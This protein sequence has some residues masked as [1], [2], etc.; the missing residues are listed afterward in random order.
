MAGSLEGY[1]HP[2][3]HWVP[4]APSRWSHASCSAHRHRNIGLLARDCLTPHFLSLLRLLSLGQ[5]MPIIPALGKL[6][7]EDCCMFEANLGYIVNSRPAWATVYIP[8]VLKEIQKEKK[9]W[10]GGSHL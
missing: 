1:Y 7:Q 10:H 8:T 4:T 5:L 2:K 6:R 3:H 9:A